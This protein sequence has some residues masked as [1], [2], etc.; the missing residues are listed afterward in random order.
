MPFVGVG[1]F[2]FLTPFRKE[3]DMTSAA[4]S[5]PTLHALIA[6]DADSPWLVLPVPAEELAMSMSWL[7]QGGE[8]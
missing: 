6:E 1:P 7:Q 8:R 4:N 3:A 5:L 2:G